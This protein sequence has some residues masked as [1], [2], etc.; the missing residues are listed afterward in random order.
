[1]GG[2]ASP[3]LCLSSSP[4]S[5]ARLPL[6]RL[7]DAAA[8]LTTVGTPYVGWLRTLL[9]TGTILGYLK[10]CSSRGQPQ[11]PKPTRYVLPPSHIAE[12][13]FLGFS[14]EADQ[15]SQNRWR[16]TTRSNGSVLVLVLV[17]VYVPFVEFGQAHN[18]H[19][20]LTYMVQ[21]SK[22][23]LLLCSGHIHWAIIPHPYLLDIYLW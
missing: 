18:I 14:L 13:Q 21:Y 3:P 22:R 16:D 15:S 10:R 11:G 8:V 5:T 7:T 19:S 12:I 17:L 23:P 9:S 20:A 6:S 1:M 4:P 2:E